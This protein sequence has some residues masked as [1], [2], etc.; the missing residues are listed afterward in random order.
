MES[1]EIREYEYVAF[2]SREKNPAQAVV[3]LHGDEGYI[4]TA[5]FGNA[6]EPLR[7]AAKTATGMYTLYYRQED[8]PIIVDMLRNEKPVY[9]IYDGASG[10]G[11]STAREPVGEG[12]F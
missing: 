8:L 11:I 3:L 7:E 9:L 10:S 2:S 1:I 12:E 6:D 4:G 5:F